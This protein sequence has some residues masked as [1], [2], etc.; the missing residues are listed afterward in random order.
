M[1]LIS[2]SYTLGN[3]SR[4]KPI[5]VQIRKP[6]FVDNAVHLAE[7]NPQNSDKHKLTIKQRKTSTY[8][9]AS[10]KAYQI[11][12]RQDSVKILEPDVAGHD[13]TSPVF[14]MSSQLSSGTATDKPPLI[15]NSV[16]P[17]QRLFL[18]EVETST[19][20]TIMSVRNLK[21]KS[22]EDIGFIRDS[23][24]FAQPVNV[25]LRT[26][27]LAMLLAKDVANEFTSV[28]LGL[29]RN[30]SNSNT[31]RRK[32][33]TKF[34]SH[35][36]HD[37]NLLTA[38]KFLGRYDNCIS[39]FDRFGNLLYVPFNFGEAGRVVNVNTRTGG[40]GVNPIANTPNKIAVQGVP[41]ALNNVSYVIMSDGERQSGRTG[42]V[43][44][45]PVVI[46]DTSVKSNDAARRIARTI[47]KANNILE[48]SMYSDGHP[49]TW[50]LRPGQVITYEGLPRIL[51]EVSHNLS[52]NSTNL[53]F[54]QVDTGIEGIL[55]GLVQGISVTEGKPDVIQ[56][57]IENDT[58]LFANIKLVSKLFVIKYN[59]G[60][61]GDGFVIGKSGGRGLIGG[62]SSY[63]TIKG[64]K[65]LAAIYGGNE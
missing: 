16:Q 54:L 35:D 47:L 26:S 19:D 38:L 57:V 28:N 58:S 63:E 65:S 9:I 46:T 31:D 62:S 56:Q 22:M 60:V 8:A 4:D 7:I 34:V 18:S 1:P 11:Q 40:K 13:S 14:Y 25:G 36:F 41:L 32:F 50:D 49:N 48:G 52:N 64:S 61:A 21:G 17:N 53:V 24:H 20:G 55:Q 23:G 59:H 37:V 42:D 10:E 33:S 43:Q 44:E 5:M 27:D 39:Y 30:P 51:T 3:I 6:K 15:Y 12:G 45:E 2:D 29:S